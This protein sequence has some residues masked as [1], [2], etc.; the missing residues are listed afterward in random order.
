M[1][2]NSTLKGGGKKK[3]INLDPKQFLSS[4]DLEIRQSKTWEL[5]NIKTSKQQGL[6][7]GKA[8]RKQGEA[9][10]PLEKEKTLSNN[11]N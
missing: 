8:K 7:K 10:I 1:P 6:A 4:N 5:T 9:N 11:I 3:R 2:V